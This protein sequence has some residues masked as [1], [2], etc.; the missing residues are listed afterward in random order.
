[1]IRA[2]QA[3]VSFQISVQRNRF[4]GRG[5]DSEIGPYPQVIVQVGLTA[6]FL[7][8][9]IPF[10]AKFQRNGRNVGLAEEELQ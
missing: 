5:A 2:I 3:L 8:R 6:R 1:M 4:G 9:I 10:R 7:R